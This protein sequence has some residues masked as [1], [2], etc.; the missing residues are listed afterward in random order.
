MRPLRVAMLNYEPLDLTQ[1]Y[2]IELHHLLTAAGHS[3]FFTAK[4][5]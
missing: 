3:A 5:Q 1:G 4:S 2:M